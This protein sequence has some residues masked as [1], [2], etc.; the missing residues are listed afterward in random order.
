MSFLQIFTDPTA[1]GSL[2]AVDNSGNLLWYRDLKR[3]G[4]NGPHAENGWDSKSGSIIGNGWQDFLHV[5]CAGDG[6]ILAVKKS[7]ELL[8]YRD[9]ARDGTSRWDP[10]SGNQIG[11]GWQVF[12]RIFSG[13]T[14]I[15]YAIR[16][17][18]ELLWYQD[19]KRDGTNG[20]SG[21]SGWH[22]N[23]G[24][25]IGVGWDK[26]DQ[27]LSIG[28]GI[29]YAVKPTGELLWYQDVA[30][31]GTNGAGGE[32]GWQSQ[33]GSQVG[34][35]WSF[36]RVDGDQEGDL[37]AVR[38][39]G[40]LLWYR[41]QKR[42]G[43]NGTAAQTGWQTNSGSQI[44]F[45]WVLSF[46]IEGYCFPLSGKPGDVVNFYMSSSEFSY[47][48]IYLRLR[49]SDGGRFSTD[50]G[51]AGP[52]I[53]VSDSFSQPAQTQPYPSEMAWRGCD[54]QT[55]FSLKIPENWQSGLYAAQCSNSNGDTAHVVFIVNPQDAVRHNLALLANTNTWTAYNAWGGNSKYGSPPAALL[56][57][58]RPN[59]GTT[60]LWDG[61][62]NHLTC[63]ELW[64]T[65][66][67]EDAGFGVDV[68]SDHDLHSGIAELREYKAI[69]LSTHPEYWTT[70][71]LDHLEA[72]LA[73]GGTVIY[74]GGNGIFERCTFTG[75]NDNQI[76]FL[77]G[78][79]GGERDPAY[80]RNLNPR[81][82]ERPVLGVAFLFDNYFTDSAPAPFKIVSEHPF[83]SDAGLHPPML[84][85]QN[86]RNQSASGWEMDA[87]T[88]GGYADS[89]PTVVSAWK[90]NDRGLPPANIQVLARGTNIPAQSDHVS[91]MTYY[92]TPT[93][94]F[95]FSAGSLCFTGSL[96]VDPALQAI[97]RNALNKAL[98]K[99]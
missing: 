42:D 12:E 84:I 58:L 34:F 53:Q 14:G 54:W 51:I 16:P 71:M 75:A 89:D 4:T 55:S 15:I 46:P 19:L 63:S 36:D 57:I 40:E 56:G 74:L 22:S 77:E 13:G 5:F 94:G 93:G 50:Q 72:Y 8:W 1:P 33:S 65:R 87:S 98:G 24:S 88:P 18:G 62:L 7:G 86:G 26:F 3:D 23:S 69:I 73:A 28:G 27:V 76:M 80:F 67:L 60:P 41:D 21:S 38:H 17:S 81:R 44:G 92:E 25:Q 20:P 2:Y 96:A 48:V 59:P 61:Q 97:V 29:I 90:G 68:Y 70:Q 66:W 47:E 45:G 99:T 32:R 49:L 85:G 37:Y 83:L 35:G 52:G 43:T 10:L 78:V 9:L 79:E 39:G 95:V 30:R 11:F 91:E 31:D 82:S 64:V 6:I